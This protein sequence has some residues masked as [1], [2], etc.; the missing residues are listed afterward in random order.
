[1]FSDFSGQLSQNNMTLTNPYFDNKAKIKSY[2][3]HTRNVSKSYIYSDYIFSR[4]IGLTLEYVD[5][6]FNLVAYFLP[7]VPD[8]SCK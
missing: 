5:W 1:M 2:L 6:M 4:I 7:F 8:K 3:V